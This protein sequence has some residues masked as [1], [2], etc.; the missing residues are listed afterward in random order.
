VSVIIVSWNTRELLRGCLESVFAQSSGIAMEVIV[1]DNASSDGSA[2]MVR[3]A[4]PQVALI[5]NDKNRGFAA[6]NN[7]GIAVAG[8]EYVLLLNSDTIVLDDAIGKAVR[9]MPP[10]AAVLGVRVL[11]PD[12]T[13]QPTCFMF[14]SPLNMAL[15]STYLYKLLPRSRFAG[16]ERMTWWQRDDARR[17]DVVTGCFMLVRRRA[18]EQVGVLDERFFMYAEETDWC[19]RFREAGWKVTF[20]PG[21]EIIHYGGASAAKAASTMSLQQRGSILLFIKKHRSRPVYWLCCGLTAAFFAVRIPYWAVSAVVSGRNRSHCVAMLRT[22]LSGA[23]RCFG[24]AD[25]LCVQVEA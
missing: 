13:L 10:D 11:N 9:L 18:I 8:G 12:R 24:G 25:K 23:L 19:Y 2:E 17:V 21:A 5:V 16:R 14:P 6:A 22:Y 4:F 15:S 3:T 20:D 7:R 1:V